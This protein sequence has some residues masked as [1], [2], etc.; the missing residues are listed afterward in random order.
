MGLDI[1]VVDTS[2]E[3][4]KRLARNALDPNWSHDAEHI[5]YTPDEEDAQL[6]VMDA[7]GKDKHP[8]KSEF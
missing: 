3:N 6:W 5:V 7:N 4:L 1:W 2:G 8:L